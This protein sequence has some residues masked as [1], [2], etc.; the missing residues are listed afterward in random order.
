MLEHDLLNILNS[1]DSTNFH[2][3]LMRLFFKA[4]IHNF[5]LLR[6]GFPNTARL[7]EHYK[8]TGEVLTGLEYE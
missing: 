7:V 8:K 5:A 4:D 2:S 3:Q 1:E 6:K